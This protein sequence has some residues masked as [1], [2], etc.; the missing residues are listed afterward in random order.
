MWEQMEN[1]FQGFFFAVVFRCSTRQQFC[2]LLAAILNIILLFTS[3]VNQCL[4]LCVRVSAGIGRLMFNSE[5]LK[6]IFHSQ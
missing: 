1:K 4:S 6:K 5:A 3:P 2:C